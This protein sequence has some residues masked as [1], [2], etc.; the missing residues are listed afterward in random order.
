MKPPSNPPIATVHLFPELDRLLIE[1]LKS[2][3]DE[4]WQKPT[5]TRLWT[6][7][8]V[9]AHL[10]DGNIRMLSMARDGYFGEHPD[11]IESYRD[12]VTYLNRLNADWVKASRRLSP[13]VLIELLSLTGPQCS[14]YLTTLDPTAPALFSVAWAGEDQSPNWF[15]VAREYTEKWHHQQQIREAVGKPGLMTRALFYPF[16]DTFMRGLPHT[17]RHTPAPDGTTIQITIRTDLGGDWYLQRFH[18]QWFLHKEASNFPEAVVQIAPEVA[19]KLFTKGVSP[20]AARPL[21]Q[22]SGNRS[23]GETAL[24]LVAVMA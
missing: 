6:V 12:L 20:E 2:L 24:T 16:I 19:W 4:E 3:T 23:L 5:L 21:V 14:A 22:I 9:A 1:L 7:K 15:H 17:Y 10:L 18:E 13:A 8:D 11:P